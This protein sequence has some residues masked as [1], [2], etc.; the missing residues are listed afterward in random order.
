[1]T[2]N[3][4]P[5]SSDYPC[6]FK[7]GS[8]RAEGQAAATYRLTGQNVRDGSRRQRADQGTLRFA[9]KPAGAPACVNTSRTRLLIPKVRMAGGVFPMSGMR[10]APRR[11]MRHAGGRAGRYRS[12]AAGRAHCQ[13]T[14]AI[15]KQETSA[16]TC[17]QDRAMRAGRSGQRRRKTEPCWPGHF[18]EPGVATAG[19][20]PGL[21]RADESVC[22][23]RLQSMMSACGCGGRGPISISIGPLPPRPPGSA[24]NSGLSWLG[25]GEAVCGQAWDPGKHPTAAGRR[26]LAASPMWIAP[27]DPDRSDPGPSD[28]NPPRQDVAMP[29][30]GRSVIDDEVS[31]CVPRLDYQHGRRTFAPAKGSANERRRTDIQ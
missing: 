30:L 17:H 1:M 10:K 8:L 5:S 14:Y 20:G 13:L 29:E 15:P 18:C 4:N 23:R 24:S 2:L 21:R 26:D 25:A 12:W 19:A 28:G 31:R 16:E 11:S 27:G 22:L 9:R 7:H 6:E 3:F